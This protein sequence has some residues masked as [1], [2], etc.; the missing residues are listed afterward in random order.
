MPEAVEIKLK[1]SFDDDASEVLDDLKED[2][3]E[4]DEERKKTQS[5]FGE[6]AN[7]FAATFAAVNLMPMLQQ[8][9]TGCHGGGSFLPLGSYPELMQEREGVR[10]VVPGSPDA[11]QIV[12][13]IE[14]A[15]MPRTVQGFHPRLKERMLGLLRLWIARGAR[16]N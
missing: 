13:V 12:R 6:F 4:T 16:D 9:C 3:E 14:E 10:T 11:S 7:Q 15:H 1:L 2:L 8:H 5:G